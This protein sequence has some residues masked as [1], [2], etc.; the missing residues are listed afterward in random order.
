MTGV[1]S[2]ITFIMA[3]KFT[4]MN[5]TTK[6]VQEFH[7]SGLY[8]Q[9]AKKRVKRRNFLRPAELKFNQNET[10]SNKNDAKFNNRQ[11]SA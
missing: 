9:R 11:F 6:R 5:R 1:D 3:I 4:R 8:T 2:T 7:M 10:K